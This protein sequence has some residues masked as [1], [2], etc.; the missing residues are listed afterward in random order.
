MLLKNGTV[1]CMKNGL[2]NPKFRLKEMGAEIKREYNIVVS[3]H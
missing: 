2:Q 1:S 3:V